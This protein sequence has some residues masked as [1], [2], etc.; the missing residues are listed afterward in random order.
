M[1]DDFFQNVWFAQNQQI[2]CLMIRKNFVNTEMLQKLSN[3]IMKI[4]K[5][6]IWEN[7]CLI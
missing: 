6:D 1:S 3:E 2:Y 5:W 4:F 7:L